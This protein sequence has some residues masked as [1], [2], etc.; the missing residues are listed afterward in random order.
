MRIVTGIF[1]LGGAVAL[2]LAF[3]S[4]CT[5]RSGGPA[6]PAATP[7]GTPKPAFEG[8]VPKGASRVAD[9]EVGRYGGRLV[10][11]LAGAPETFN[12]LLSNDVSSMNITHLMFATCYDFHRLRQEDEPG[13][14][15]R[16]DRSDD[17]LKYTFKLREGLRW[18]D[19]HPLTVDDFEFSYK[20][21]IDPKIPNSAKDL[22]KQGTNEKGEPIFPT[23][24]K[25][26]DRTFTYQLH[27]KDVLFHAT[28]GSLWVI[29]K[30]KWEK[31]HADG[32]FG[33]QMTVQVKPEDL[34]TSGAFRLRAYQDAESVLLER[35]PHFWKVDSAG[36]RLPYLD[37]IMF[38]MVPDYNAMN[39]RFREG[40]LDMLEVRPEDFEVLRREEGSSD[41]ALVDMGAGFN[42][43]YL[44]FNLDTRNN[45]EG[46]PFVDPIMGA[47]FR[48]VNFRKAVSH[49][50]DRL[51]MVRT[52]LN[53]RGEPLWSFYSPANKKWS[54]ADKVH[55]YPY[56]LD[57]ARA[58]LTSEGFQFADGVLKDA[59]GN[60][61]EFTLM[62]NSENPGRIAML[63]VIEADLKKLGMQVRIRPVPFNDL[64]TSMRDTRDYDAILLGWGTGVP[65]DPSQSK[66][67]MLS[68]GRGH[69]WMPEQDKPATEWEAK[70]DQLQ[71][72]GT[73]AFT[74][75]ER[76][77]PFEALLVL[78]SDVQPQ[79]QLVV[80]HVAF[81]SR[82][83]VG[84]F[85]PSG[86]RPELFWNAESLYLKADKRR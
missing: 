42:T 9:M 67:V 43:N 77:V 68:S 70:M 57:K 29:P 34:V 30:H 54:S 51:G 58:Y 72:A 23:F 83:N 37:T 5:D 59:Q 46:K 7:I 71:M 41:Y 69:H 64:L 66:N 61:V 81:A 20:V 6:A 55:Q 19:G 84:N 78:F 8:E 25:V 12:P 63:N 16:Y 22:F 32:T 31:S 17:G 28:V 18:S 2:S 49:A 44:S 62:T 65:P 48:N 52:V 27:A 11:G 53:G 60:V 80:P 36:N 47:W 76:K 13:L 40:K 1:L 85:K 39:M 56:D 24:T 3:G 86:L 4:S 14:C 38:L 15:E 21:L 35:N 26:D 73:E 10:L 50:I 74:Y 45:K 75:E 82:K 79:I 33:Q